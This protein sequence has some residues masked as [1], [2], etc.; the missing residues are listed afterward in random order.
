MSFAFSVVLGELT[1]ET[2]LRVRWLEKVQCT[3]AQDLQAECL[4]STF[5]TV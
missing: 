1:I 3:G 2:V 4:G 5:G